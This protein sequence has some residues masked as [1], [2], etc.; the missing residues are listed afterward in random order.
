[1]EPGVW[2]QVLTLPARKPFRCGNLIPPLNRGELGSAPHLEPC[3]PLL[4]APVLAPGH[5]LLCWP[6]TLSPGPDNRQG[7][8]AG[9]V[10]PAPSLILAPGDPAGGQRAQLS[11]LTSPGSASGASCAPGHPVAS[12]SSSV[13]EAL[14]SQAAL[15]L[16]LPSVSNE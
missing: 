3:L 2:T 13:L 12:V 7:R 4:P 6:L 16:S 10:T 11:W 8:W 1:M 14:A 15:I 5:C 9:H